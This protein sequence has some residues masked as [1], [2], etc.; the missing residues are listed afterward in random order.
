MK[1]NITEKL[2]FDG[3]P[4]LIIKGSEIEVDASAVTVLKLMDLIGNGEGP[5][6]KQLVEM[7]GLIFA[8][9]EQEKIKE[10]NLNMTDFQILIQEAVDAITGGA[11]DTGE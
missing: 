5:T 3:N 7:F 9:K 10:L 4:V 2:N 8:P 1:K 11:E 6:P